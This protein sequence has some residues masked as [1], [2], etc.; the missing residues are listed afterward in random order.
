MHV[1]HGG[2]AAEPYIG[3]DLIGEPM[4]YLPILVGLAFA[5]GFFRAA[6]YERM[7]PM[8]WTVS[9]VGLTLIMSYLGTGIFL[10]ILAQLGLFGVMWWYNANRKPDA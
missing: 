6:Q 1:F 7:S 8:P 10:V 3:R 5:I 2:D 4:A 9:S